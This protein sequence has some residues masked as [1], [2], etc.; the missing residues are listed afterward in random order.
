[1]RKDNTSPDQIDRRISA[2]FGAVVLLLGLTTAWV[3]SHLYLSL[4]MQ[5]ENRLAGAITTILSEAINR[6]AFSGKHHSRLFVEDMLARVPELAYISVETEDGRVLAHSNPALNDSSVLGEGR[7][8]AIKSL[9]TDQPVL[10]EHKPANGVIKEIV[11]PYRG[12]FD[13]QTVGTVRVGVQVEATRLAQQTTLYKLLV[14]VAAL[15]ALAIA[16]VY[17]LSRRFG[18]AM[19]VLGWQLQGILDHAPLGVAICDNHSRLLAHSAELGKMA[20]HP[21][22]NATLE[23]VLSRAFPEASAA[24]S[25]LQNQVFSGALKVEREVHFETNG[26]PRYWHISMFPIARDDANHPLLICTL[27]HDISERKQAEEALRASE[28]QFKSLF[29]QSPISNLIH[30][31]DSGEIIDANTAAFVSYGYSS[32]EELKAGKFWLERPYSL[33]EALAWIRKA[34]DQGPQRFEWLSRRVTG[35]LFWEH[36]HLSPVV[37]NG[38]E[39]ILA[40]GIDITERKRLEMRLADQLAFKQAL[41]DTIPYAVFYK[42]AATRFMGCNVAYEKTFGIKLEDFIGKRVLD[43]EYL[44]EQDRLAYQAEDEATIASVGHVRKEMA[45]PF[46]DGLI[47][48]TLYSVNGFRQADGTPGGVI[49]I[50]V[51]IS[52]LKRAE[53]ALRESEARY[54]S[55]IEN[56]QDMYYRTDVQGRLVL[57]SPSTPKQ[58]GY[59][60]VDEVLGCLASDFWMQPE[61]RQELLLR[62]KTEGVV[63]DY[64]VLLKAK[65]GKPL[66]VS[67]T[68]AYYH[69]DEGNVLG[70]EGI[71]RDITERKRGEEALKKSR[72]ELEERVAERTRE[73][74]EAN[75]RLT[76]LDNLKSTFLNTVSHD[77]RTPLTSILGFSKIIQRDFTRRFLPLAEGDSVLRNKASKILDNLGVIVSEGER[78][79]RLVS[80]FLDLSRIEDGRYVWKD[81]TTDLGVLIRGAVSSM[82]GALIQKHGVQIRVDADSHLPDLWVDP[83]R[84]AQVLTNLL[85]N[86]IKFTSEG[87]VTLTAKASAESI[88]VSV[89]DTGMGIP[90]DELPMIFDKF[91][92]VGDDTLVAEKGTGLGLA[93]CKQIVEHYDGA[94]WVESTQ[95][96]GSVFF[97][98]LPLIA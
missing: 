65:D 73:L 61:L 4:Q 26:T 38:V 89:A 16:A 87:T 57:L 86:A 69:D 90:P 59:D 66:L 8:N 60:S 58:L 63:K 54:R 52:D 85:S 17:F 9:K 68:S 45:I 40:S 46:V 67:A 27:M 47:H 51:D 20:G 2:S 94:I 92:Q 15:T 32:V 64:E 28:S 88:R 39:R 11:V 22:E 98:E 19:Q 3:A 30:D 55:I 43:L 6:V 78:L 80:D 23:S 70:V 77:L 95:G 7:D 48:Q 56:I 76:E 84:I 13:A 97:F 24:L 50:I 71:F 83:D 53:V 79:T 44:P 21:G 10:S 75:A 42:D 81:K 35:E 31:K 49:G 82:Q 25:M 93:I 91:Y 12:G 33:E 14:L 29:S 5:E 37:I 62:I 41:M 96:V 34:A 1:M 72:D 74:T 18:G 36:V